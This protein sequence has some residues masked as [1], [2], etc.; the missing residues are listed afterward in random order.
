[1]KDL[2]YTIA[3]LDPASNVQSTSKEETMKKADNEENHKA[4][5]DDEGF[6]VPLGTAHHNNKKLEADEG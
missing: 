2:K 6:K 5:T 1:M 3:R 4:E